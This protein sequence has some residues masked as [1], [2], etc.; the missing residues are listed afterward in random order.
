MS[1]PGGYPSNPGVNRVIAVSRSPGRIAG[2]TKAL[3]ACFFHRNPLDEKDTETPL[4]P[5][6]FSRC[7][8]DPPRSRNDTGESA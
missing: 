6:G 2:A 8:P 3:L 5:I 4:G 7:R 1:G